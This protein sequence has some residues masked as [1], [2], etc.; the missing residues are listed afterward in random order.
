[1]VQVKAQK[2]RWYLK[3]AKIGEDKSFLAKSCVSL[4]FLFTTIPGGRESGT[5]TGYTLF[6][7]YFITKMYTLFITVTFPP[8]PRRGRER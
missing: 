1:M 8:P 4:S 3:E 7:S 2:T 5:K 6:I